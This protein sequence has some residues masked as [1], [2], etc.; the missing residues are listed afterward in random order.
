VLVASSS[1]TLLPLHAIGNAA[2]Q[3]FINQI[4][5][6]VALSFAG[7]LGQALDLR[8]GTWPKPYAEGRRFLVIADGARPPQLLFWLFVRNCLYAFHSLIYTYC[9]RN[10]KEDGI[11]E[12]RKIRTGLSVEELERLQKFG[13]LSFKS[14]RRVDHRIE[15]FFPPQT[16]H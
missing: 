8:I 2:G 1:S 15:P 11:A 5:D 4:A 9:A 7:C 14:I 16:Q 12:T 13:S 3:R 6:N 10:D